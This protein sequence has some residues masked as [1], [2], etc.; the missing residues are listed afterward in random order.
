[1]AK[2]IKPELSIEMKVRNQQESLILA[3][4]LV[5]IFQEAQVKNMT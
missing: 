5:D 2:I 3:S 1:M 4:S